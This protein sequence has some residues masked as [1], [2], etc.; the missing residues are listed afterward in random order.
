MIGHTVGSL[1]FH[2]THS[3]EAPVEPTVLRL[4]LLSYRYV[5]SF[6]LNQ[7]TPDHD[8]GEHQPLVGGNTSIHTYVVCYQSSTLGRPLL[9]N[10]PTPDHDSGE[11]Q[12]LVG[13][14]TSIHTYLVCYQSTTPG[15][16]L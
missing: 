9:L 5:P 6:M 11:H 14:N 12:P 8:S 13:G 10:R 16:P 7:P 3:V 2:P 4:R 15:R 1:T